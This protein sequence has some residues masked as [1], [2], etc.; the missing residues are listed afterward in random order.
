VQLGDALQD[1]VEAAVD[2]AMIVMDLT[3]NVA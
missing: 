1:Q 3:T 2:K